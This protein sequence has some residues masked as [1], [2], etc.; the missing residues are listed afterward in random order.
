MVG[1]GISKGGTIVVDFANGE[2]ALTVKPTR[3]KRSSLT[4]ANFV[5]DKVAR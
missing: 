3:V 2:Y 1:K 4:S 5:S